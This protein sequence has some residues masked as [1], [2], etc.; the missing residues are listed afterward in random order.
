MPSFK[1]LILKDK[2]LQKK[3]HFGELKRQKHQKYAKYGHFTK[4]DT[5]FYTNIQNHRIK[6]YTI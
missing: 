4:S 6:F 1:L 5:A 2:K 3:L